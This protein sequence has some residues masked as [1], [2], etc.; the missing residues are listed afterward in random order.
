[1]ICNKAWL[2]KQELFKM[3]EVISREQSSLPEQRR[4]Q[5]VKRCRVNG[6]VE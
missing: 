5:S 3:A 4:P 2:V 6:T 1:M